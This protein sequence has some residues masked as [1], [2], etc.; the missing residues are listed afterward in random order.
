MAEETKVWKGHSGGH[1]KKLTKRA[2]RKKRRQPTWQK[3][4][5]ERKGVNQ[6]GIKGG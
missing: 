6:A 2:Y 1:R 4:W 3:G 5:K